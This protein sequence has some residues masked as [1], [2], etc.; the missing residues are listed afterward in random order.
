MTD[1]AELRELAYHLECCLAREPSDLRG[2]LIRAV[3]SRLRRIADALESEAAL[4]K[5]GG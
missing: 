3:A 5:P 4:A 2:A 1:P